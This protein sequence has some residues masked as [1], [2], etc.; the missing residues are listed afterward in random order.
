M[1]KHLISILAALSWLVAAAGCANTGG[2]QSLEITVGAT[3]VPHA[4]ILNHIKDDLAADGVTLHV[5]EFSDYLLINPA[6][7]DGQI[8]ANFFQHTP[9]LNG[10]MAD[11]GHQLEAVA[12][13]HIEP[14]GVYS[15]TI[16]SLDELADGAIVAIPN[17]RTNRGRALVLLEK[18]G[19]VHLRE[20]VSIDATLDDIVG[21]PKNL[22]I[23][24]LE[25]VL[26]PRALGETDI[27]VI[28]TNFALEVDLIPSRDA[29]VMEDIDS[30][31]A[32]VL[33]VR[34]ENKDD[35]AVQK[36][37][38]ALTSQSVRAFLEEKYAGSIVPA[39]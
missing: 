23:N 5:R 28:N 18:H 24:E 22:Q 35:E 2:G 17:D 15:K 30:P 4:E 10:Y 12:A 26:I 27:A 37:I 29:I 34:P 1:K 32:N 8:D 25:A 7:N 20:G 31:F 9:Y 33:V 19:L 16:Q 39:F 13:I 21:N 6:L 14:I 3:A 11:S 36:L 38:A